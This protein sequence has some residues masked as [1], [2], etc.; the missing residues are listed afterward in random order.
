MNQ[1]RPPRY[2]QQTNARNSSVKGQVGQARRDLWQFQ[3]LFGGERA[4]VQQEQQ[5]R[6]ALIDK[7]RNFWV[8]GVLEKSLHYQAT[9]ELNLEKRLDVLDQPF[10]LDW[11]TPNQL[12]QDLP[13]GTK[14]ID[15]FSQMG[16][17]GTL[18]IL[19]E[20]GSGKTIT[21]LGLTRDLL[22]SV[23]QNENQPIPVVFNLSSW[24]GG[25]QTIANWLVKEL[26]EKYQVS[27]ALG[28]SWVE[29]EKLLLL[30]D[31]LDEV[32]ANLRDNCV[33]ALNQFI[34]RY[35]R[36]RIIVCS[37]TKDYEA[38]TQLLKFQG[39]ILIKLLTIE[40]V[41]QYL[42]KTGDKLAGVRAA[43]QINS[44]LQELI[45][46]PLM[47]STVALTYQDFAVEDLPQITSKAE[48]IKH[49]FDSYIKRMF[50]RR[51]SIKTK[52][53]EKLARYWLSW[54]AQYMS[55]ESQS[56]FLIERMQP[57][58]YLRSKCEYRIYYIGI[59]FLI[60]IL[61]LCLGSLFGWLIFGWFGSVLFGLLFF[62]ITNNFFSVLIWVQLVSNNMNVFFNLS[63]MKIR[64]F[65]SLSFSW[66]KFHKSS[67]E[68][69]RVALSIG[70]LVGIII[71]LFYSLFD[72]N[73]LT[74]TTYNLFSLLLLL[75]LKVF[76]GLLTGFF[77]GIPYSI[78]LWIVYIAPFMMIAEV[79][80]TI[81][82]TTFPNQ[83][84]WKSLVNSG[85][86]FLT[87]LLVFSLVGGLFGWL[88]GGLLGGIKLGL[89][90]GALF[91]FFLGLVPGLACIQHL[92][93]RLILSLR[94][95]TPWNYARF[96]HYATERIFLQKVGG[97]YIFIHRL[98][99][100]HFAQMELDQVRR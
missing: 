20:P 59:D 54:L 72:P 87:V 47:L 42:A 26:E 56:I 32:P 44:M 5:N 85:I 76:L 15:I 8:K 38:L 74:Y 17:G 62:A 35:G 1:P 61:G 73:L 84:I 71:G 92:I 81:E 43:I 75:A 41:D 19:G 9:I 49:L 70:C 98:L 83:G 29:N 45:K 88:L 27:Q 68:S 80:E 64:I 25:G 34:Q 82:K 53:K 97:G 77:I 36:T 23:D 69:F 28:K 79:G 2:S 89:L 78:F 7:V 55:Q 90:V 30:L 21:L 24:R 66:I 65:E 6:K 60:S 94:G 14:V 39:A 3:F 86:V 93:L 37:R 50:F 13:V 22:D 11:I 95:N 57:I 67:D 4:K 46:T 52:Y 40:Q 51:Q 100:E 10:N 18:L 48:F 91:G 58:I 33:I 12:Q 63:K 99:L 31:G 96:L 16:E